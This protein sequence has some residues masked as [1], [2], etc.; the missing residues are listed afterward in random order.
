MDSKEQLDITGML[1][2]WSKGDK[3]ALTEVIPLVYDDLRLIARSG[4]ELIRL[5][6]NRRIAQ[7]L[8][9]AHNRDL[10]RS[11]LGASF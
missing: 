6:I 11:A 3:Q 7:P 10:I 1:T 5:G 9:V 2:A 8:S 4:G